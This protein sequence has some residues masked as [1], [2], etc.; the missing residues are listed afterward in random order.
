MTRIACHLGVLH[1]ND[2]G[3]HAGEW[4]HAVH[5]H[6][7]RSRRAEGAGP[8]T[9]KLFRQWFDPELYTVL[10]DLRQGAIHDDELL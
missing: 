9:Y 2:T 3:T 5:G 7:V 6:H 8:A 1:G 4:M 10:T